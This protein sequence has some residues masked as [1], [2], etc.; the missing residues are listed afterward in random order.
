M[1]WLWKGIRALTAA[2]RALRIAVMEFVP[3]LMWTDSAKSISTYSR[4]F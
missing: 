4:T 3:N 2:A 1:D